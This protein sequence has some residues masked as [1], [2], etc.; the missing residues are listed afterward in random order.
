M[1]EKAEV[2]REALI[3]MAER[4]RESEHGPIAYSNEWV[5]GGGESSRW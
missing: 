1:T 2:I 5:G 4:E 3:R